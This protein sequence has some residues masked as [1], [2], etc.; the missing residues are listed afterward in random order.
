MAYE[1]LGEAALEYYPCRY[2]HSKLLFR[3]P[4]KK[5]DGAYISVIGGTETY[6][7]YVD[8]PFP[9]M[10]ERWLEIPVANLGCVNAGND[11]FVN[12]ASVLEICQNSAA[13]IVQVTGAQNMSNRFYSVHPRRNDRFV[14]ASNALTTIYRDVDF[15]EY[16]FTRYLLTDL[17]KKSPG[18]FELVRQELQAAWIGRMKTLLSRIGGT[19][20][21][22]WMADHGP[23]DPPSET[24]LG[25]DPMFVD[26]W[27]LEALGEHLAGVVEVV[28]TPDEIA[29]G[30]ERM[31]YTALEEPAAQEMLGPVVH[32]A[33][34]QK[35]YEVLAPLI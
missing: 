9:A 28:A 14:K 2:G 15:T 13:T 5:L 24:P 22:L 4:R 25:H 33:A 7:K 8:T 29:A 32:E 34:A 3:G 1:H 27:M 17:K 16:H 10:L 18:K 21:L 12:D 31:M 19:V 23:G 11:A 20:L 26:R 30:F 6:G 35:L